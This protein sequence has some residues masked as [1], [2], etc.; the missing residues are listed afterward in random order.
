MLEVRQ[1][2]TGNEE[3]S[4]RNSR[5]GVLCETLKQNGV[6]HFHTDWIE[7]AIQLSRGRIFLAVRASSAKVLR[8]EKGDQREAGRVKK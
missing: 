5:G 6:G 4:L 1:A 3:R 8:Q 7:Q 2:S